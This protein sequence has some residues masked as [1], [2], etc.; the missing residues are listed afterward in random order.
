MMRLDAFLILI[1]ILRVVTLVDSS[2]VISSDCQPKC[3]NIS[4]PYPFGINNE[5]CY[6][7][8][9][10]KIECLENS[11]GGGEYPVLSKFNMTI[12]NISLP[13]DY[14]GSQTSAL[15]GSV[16]VRIPVTSM[17][18]SINGKETE[19]PLNLT[20]SPYFV[21]YDNYLVALGCKGKASLTN[22]EPNKVVCDL[23]CTSKT[24]VHSNNNIPFLDNTGCS[25]NTLPLSGNQICTEKQTGCDGNGCCL[26]NMLSGRQQVIGVKIEKS[27][28]NSTAKE[29][30]IVAFL[31]DESYTKSNGT[32]PM[33]LFVM[34]YSTVK[35]GWVIQT[36]NLSFLN[37]LSCKQRNKYTNTF[38]IA[39]KIS[40]VCD[41]STIFENS[42]ASCGCSRGY[43][44]N[45]YV[46]N[47][48]EDIDECSHKS[49]NYCRVSDTCVNLPGT[50]DC[51]GDKTKAIMAGN[52][53][54]FS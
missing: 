46:F 29:E 43:T 40:C 15:F 20:G 38:D 31:S 50:Y 41:N 2:L 32:N 49:K 53:R 54:V 42:Y 14:Y 11:T 27:E 52:H 51:V 30:C 1:S 13:E 21:E 16:R 28:E 36:N 4:I 24:E 10:Y 33:P 6:L 44:G 45:A 37:S 8:E 48:C 7:N 5:G 18:C 35:L 47:G 22:I 12:V 25:N 19:S 23:D 3:G 39:R 26:K 9:Y 34:G 17:G